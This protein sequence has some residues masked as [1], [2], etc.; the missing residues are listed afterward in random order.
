MQQFIEFATNHWDLFLALL[1]ILLMLSG[2]NLLSVIRGIK[3][4]GPAEAT[5]LINHE[6]GIVID[7][8][9]DKEFAEGH[10][11]NSLHIPMTSVQQRITEIEKYK[12]KPVI[13]SCRSG[14]RSNTVCGW[15]RK[16]N[17]ENVSNLK[18]GVMAWQNASLPLSKK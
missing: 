4:I 10:I 6:G 8:R 1:I 11:I 5:Q 16:H 15:L 7:V 9:E 17:F 18:G 14:A 2:T 3:Q 13:V 12:Q